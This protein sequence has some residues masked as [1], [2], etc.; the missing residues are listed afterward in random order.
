MRF[1]LILAFPFIELWLMIEVGAR[2]GALTTI[3]LLIIS[4]A[5]GLA[6]LRRQGVGALL[7]LNRKAAAGERP[8][9]VALEGMIL[10][11]AGL[12]FVFPGFIS[13]VLG[14]VC[15]LPFVRRALARRWINRFQSVHVAHFETRTQDRNIIDGDFTEIPPEDRRLP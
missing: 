3:G 6:V 10:A 1:L 2:I 15:L 8:E 7:D 5:A 4:A 12:L 13:D 11:G 9:T 14:F